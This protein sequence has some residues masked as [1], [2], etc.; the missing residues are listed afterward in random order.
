MRN[1]KAPEV[2]NQTLRVDSNQNFRVDNNNALRV[3]NNNAS[4]F[5]SNNDLTLECDNALRAIIN[6]IPRA[7]S[8]DAMP[9]TGGCLAVKNEFSMYLGS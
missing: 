5:D 7:D 6:D 2:G 9:R 3:D 4:R 8:Y 1:T